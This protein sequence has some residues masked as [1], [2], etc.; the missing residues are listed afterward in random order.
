MYT[1][2]YIDCFILQLHQ[3]HNITQSLVYVALKSQDTALHS[4]NFSQN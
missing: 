3:G 4:H 2:P 1:K